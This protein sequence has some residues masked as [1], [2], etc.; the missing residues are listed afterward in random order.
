MTPTADPCPPAE[1]FDK[2]ADG[3]DAGMGN[4][5][6]RLVGSSPADFLRVKARWLDRDLRKQGPLDVL[7]YGCGIGG[8]LAELALLRPADRLAGC[9]VSA[10]MLDR[11]REKSDREFFHLNPDGI[12]ARAGRYDVVLVSAVLH[13]VM[14]PDRP[15]VYR[16]LRQ[17]LRPTGRLYVFEHNPFNPVTTWVVKNTP[18]D[19]NAVLISAPTVRRGLRAVGFDQFLTRY[20][21]FFP[22]RFTWLEPGEALF[23]R[24]PLGGQFVVRA[25]PA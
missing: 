15:A 2:Y 23:R 4:P 9:D 10:R 20:L 1:E 8:L 24:V 19:R 12:A 17:L 13:H 22:P 25:R 16:N 11:A 21:M 6:K 7:D 14:P 5:I 18:I 3:Y